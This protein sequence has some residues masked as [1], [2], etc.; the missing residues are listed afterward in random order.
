VS[1]FS[2]GGNMCFSVPM[3]F[4]HEVVMRPQ[5]YEGAVERKLAAIAAFY[6]STDFT[7]SR[8]DRRATNIRPD[9][10]LPQIFTDLFDASYLWPPKEIDT[11]SPY[12][13]PGVAD[14]VLL[15][16]ALPDRI[17]LVTCE[18]DELLDEGERFYKRLLGLGKQVWYRMVPG[19]THAW[20]KSPNPRTADQTAEEVYEEVCR[21]LS[22]I[23]SS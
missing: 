17:V 21:E 16:D 7:R 20:D 5:Q 23:F 22:T 1:G 10:E 2:A 9:K 14:E 13:S 3:R 4:Y 8:P 12:L 19:V 6:P 15:R 11:N 18:W